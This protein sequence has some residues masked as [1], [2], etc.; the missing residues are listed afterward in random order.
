MNDGRLSMRIACFFVLI[1]YLLAACSVEDQPAN[2]PVPPAST[3]PAPT[4]EVEVE[5]R[6]W[7]DRPDPARGEIVTVFGTLKVTGVYR[8]GVMMTAVWPDPNHQ[9][10]VP[11]CLTRTS[12]ELGSCAIPVEN[13]PPGEF[14][15]ITITFDFDGVKYTTQTGFTPQP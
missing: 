4:P 15:P 2:T 8:N 14:V 10:G 1:A 7:V 13:F 3:L 5:V 9:R 11:N 6:S 12:Y